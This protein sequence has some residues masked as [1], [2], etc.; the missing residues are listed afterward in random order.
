MTNFTPPRSGKGAFLNDRGLRVAGRRELSR[1]VIGCGLPHHRH[2]ATYA[3]SR[4]EM[5]A[6][7]DRWRACAAFG[8]AA[9]DLAYVAAGRLDGFWERDL[10]PGTW[11]P[12]IIVR[13]AG[14]PVSGIEGDDDPLKSGT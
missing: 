9:L 5:A 3:L 6:D 2:A 13:E 4:K 12:A 1:R 7:Q 10:S 14:G 11:R 8:A